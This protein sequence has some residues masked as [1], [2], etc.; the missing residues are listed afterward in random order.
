MVSV[1]TV[2]VKCG[3]N[4]GG[5][6]MLKICNFHILKTSATNPISLI[7]IFL[8]STD[9]SIFLDIPVFRQILGSILLAFVPGGIFL[10]ILK[11]DKIGLTEKFVL[12]VGLS[13]SFVMLI[14]ILI[15]TIYPHLGYETPLS[16]ISL[17]ISISVAVLILAIIAHLRD[18]F[19]FF[20]KR[21]DLQLDI[22]DKAIILIPILFLP[23]SVL[24]M[25]I[26]NTTD[27]NAMLMALLFLIPSYV[28]LISIFH[29][30]I[31]KRSYP[32]IIFLISISLVL[33]LGM[34]SSHIIG[35]DTH[36]EY[37]FISA[38]LILMRNGRS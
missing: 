33:L 4:L 3:K 16:V 17:V 27:N 38:N 24:G 21:T 9:L 15:N 19:A 32:I 23:L 13:I 36:K 37:F 5:K 28:I 30:Q 34:R 26:M 7:L 10:C 8:I 29:N 20:T 6:L 2:N 11:S 31:P 1:R 14:G 18:G 35:S 22:R 25:H 12:S